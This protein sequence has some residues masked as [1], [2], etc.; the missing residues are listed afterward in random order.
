MGLTTREKNLFELRPKEKRRRLSPH[1][2][3]RTSGFHTG[4]SETLCS[5]LWARRT[6]ST[7]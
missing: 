1:I 3:I 2:L 5:S 4:Y 7:E 6:R